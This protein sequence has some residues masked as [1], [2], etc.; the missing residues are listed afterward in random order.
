MNTYKVYVTVRVCSHV[1]LQAEKLLIWKLWC[2]I[3]QVLLVLVYCGG[4]I[5]KWIERSVLFEHAE[6]QGNAIR[7]LRSITESAF[8]EAFQQWKKI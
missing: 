1:G 2:V 6:I 7:E 3:K 5:L 4:G 8:Q